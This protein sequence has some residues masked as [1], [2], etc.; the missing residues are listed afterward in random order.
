MD[1]VS[2]EQRAQNMARIRCKNTAPETQL[3]RLVH[4]LG[5]RY[6]L[7]AN[8][9]PG[10]PDMVFKKR[11]KLIFLHGCFWHQHQKCTDGRI[12]NSRQSYWRPKLMGNKARDARNR[13]RLRS[14]GWRTLVIWECELVSPKAVQRK[15]QGFLESD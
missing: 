5:F 9:L 4:A 13:L 10:R 2:I 8:K 11:K 1:R 6:R 12:P 14:L 15:V 7:H 3:R